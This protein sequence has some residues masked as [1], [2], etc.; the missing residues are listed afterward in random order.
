MWDVCKG[1]GKVSELQIA[2]DAIDGQW[3]VGPAELERHS[4][5]TS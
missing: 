5:G 3:R 2:A 4:N 1:E